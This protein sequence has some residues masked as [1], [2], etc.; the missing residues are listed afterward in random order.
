[1]S[2]N[3]HNYYS[4]KVFGKLMRIIIIILAVIIII[5]RHLSC[6]NE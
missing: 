5:N 3:S 6:H 1:M 4:A 2:A